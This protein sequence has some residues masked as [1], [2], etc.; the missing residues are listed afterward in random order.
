MS[1]KA[2]HERVEQ[3]RR[4][5]N[6]EARPTDP[7]TVLRDR[8]VNPGKQHRGGD[9]QVEFLQA[10]E[11]NSLLEYL[12]SQGVGHEFSAL[13]TPLL[14]VKLQ[15]SEFIKAPVSTARMIRNTYRSLSP[16]EAASVS[17]WNAITLH[18]IQTNRLEAPYLAASSDKSSGRH[19]LQQAL[20][21]RNRKRQS[22]RID[23]CVRTVFRTMGGLRRIRGYVS[24]ISDC[25]LSRYWWMG[26]AIENSAIDDDQAWEELNRYWR[27]IAEY[28]IRRLTIIGNPVLMHGLITHITSHPVDTVT[29]IEDVLKRMGVLFSEV[30]AHSWSGNEV[31][32][33]LAQSVPT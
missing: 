18:N 23:D 31:Q 14:P 1:E 28:A 12:A 19:R 30:S 33:L 16:Q 20:R 5:L 22:K 15:E 4:I 21:T 10:V 24:V 9:A 13:D 25:T 32:N 29:G 7:L 3:V 8:L 6:P 27:V 26:H 11:G 2:G 17:V